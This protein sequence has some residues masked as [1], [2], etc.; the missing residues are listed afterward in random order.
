[1][2]RRATGPLSVLLVLLFCGGLAYGQGSGASS[3]SGLVMDSGGGVIPGA[4]VVIKSNSVT[5]SF[6]TVTNGRG[7]FSVPALDP[8]VYT[9]TVS[10][11][12]FKTAV[13]TN[14]RLLPA[15]PADVRVTLE[16]GGLEETV[17]VSGA[18]ELVQTRS[19]SVSSTVNVDQINA[20]PLPTRNAMNFVAYLPGVN[21]T[22]IN[23]D[24]VFN[25]LPNSAVAISLD[26][27]NNN[28]NYNKSTE[29]LFAMVTPRQDAVEAVT[30]TTATPGAESGG[31][32]SVSIQF[33]TRA[34]TDRFSGSLYE[35][36]RRPGL[37]TNYYF[38]ALRDL[39]KNDVKIDQYGGRLGG[40]MSI[41]GLFDGRGKAYFFVNYEE[42][43]MPNAFSRLR[44]V[45]SPAGQNGVFQYNAGGSIQQVNLYEL[46][47]RFGQTATP[48]PTV[49]SVL[50]LIRAS[51]AT[52]GTITAKSDPNTMS[53][54]F[55][56]P[57]DQIEKQP[58]ARLDFQLS[59][60]HR[61][62]GTWTHQIVDRTP[63][64]LN[65]TD[66][67]FPGAPNIRRYLSKRNI[68][69]TAIRSVL[70]NN[71][72][73]EL[74]GGVKWGPSFFGKPEWNGPAS[75]ADQGGR[76]LGLGNTG[77]T[78]TNWWVANTPN[79]R[80]AWS[81]NIDEAMNWEK[82]SHSLKFGGSYYTGYSWTTNQTMVPQITF[83]VDSSDPAN[84]M[85]T[86]ANF[87]G[88]SS[89]NLTT[90]KNLY[91][92]LTGRVN[93]ITANAGLGDNGEYALLGP[94]EVRLQQK[95][96][97][98]FV[99]DVWRLTPQLTMNLGL[100]WDVQ[101]PIESANN[102]LSMSTFEDV[103][104]ISG[105]GSQYR[106]QHVPARRADGPRADLRAVQQ[107]HTR[108]QDRLEQRRAKRRLRLAAG[109]RGWLPPDAPRRSGPGDRPGR[110]LG[111]LQP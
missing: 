4:T 7:A 24:A 36:M 94:R 54:S 59:S 108:L 25:G 37:N 42:F 61:L 105:V 18:S 63:D 104:G 55:L 97:G 74:R 33:V 78:L 14:V 107:G 100:R 89:S 79:G 43:R 70:R 21:T 83:G 6:D 66:A 73:N 35:Y 111:V 57:G 2:R 87:P 85:F 91:A 38:N 98:L 62:T 48:D 86:A 22:G 101:G 71:L 93:S 109:R 46:A 1:M 8:G 76:A 92:L 88:A 44:T 29:G 23:R 16:V 26:G 68:G 106:M 19:A 82:G 60:K 69:S 30:V 20:L 77:T 81:W 99:Q 102:S 47:A 72:V 80:S 103:C 110:L 31:H 32:G 9:V 5:T 75:Y 51:T 95:E 39:P 49:A 65:G 10:L 96:V 11:V 41:P 56:S 90:A 13:I 15:T 12:G 50:N 58:T 27:V 53:Y 34:G 45:L 64:M 67:R 17:T 84:A 3:L 40:P 52:T 28:E